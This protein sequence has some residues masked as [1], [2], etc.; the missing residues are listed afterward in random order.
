MGTF[1]PNQM[2]EPD[3]DQPVAEPEPNPWE[4]WQQAGIDPAKYDP[5]KAQNALSFWE[6][7]SNRDQRP[8]A[9]SHLAN[10]LTPEERQ[11]IAAAAAHQHDDLDSGPD[12]DSYYGD[13]G[14][15][16]YGY[17]GSPSGVT[18]EQVQQI[19]QQMA[20][21]QLDAFQKKQAEEMAAR[22]VREEFERELMRVQQE[23]GYDNDEVSWIA[24]SAFN[25]RNQDPFSTHQQIVDKAR[26]RFDQQMDRRLQ[27]LAERQRAASQAAP[28]IPSG[29]PPSPD[30]VPSSPE[31]A[32]RMFRQMGGQ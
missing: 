10:Q 8:F 31:E 18:V 30:Q 25:L 17:E 32:E 14:A 11:Q 15:D 16:E 28:S 1:D 12:S 22:Q 2:P 26:Q 13:P 20:Q 6:A 29:G 24:T 9:V 7:L 5:H 3:A 21:Q 23:G 19:A 4:A 27:K